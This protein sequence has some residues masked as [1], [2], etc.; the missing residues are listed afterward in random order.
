M[1]EATSAT[2]TSETDAVSP[3]DG[4]AASVVSEDTAKRDA[5]VKTFLMSDGSYEAV[6]Y[7]QPVHYQQDGQWVDI[8]NTLTSETLNGDLLTGDVTKNGNAAN[9][10][11]YWKTTANDFTVEL[12]ASLDTASPVMVSHNGKD[13]RFVLENAAPADAGVTQPQSDADKKAKLTKAEKDADK[14]QKK[15]LENESKTTPKNQDSGADYQNVAA[16]VSLNYA[17]SGQKL[18]ESILLDSPPA[19]TSFTFDVYC[20]NLVAEV[21]PDQ[22]VYLYEKNHK[23]DADPVFVIAAP[24]M[25]DSGE[26]YTDAVAVA[27]TATKYGCTY[28]LTPDADWLNS[29]DRVYPVTLDP[30]VYTSTAPSNILDTYAD[31]SNPNSQYGSTYDMY[32]GSKYIQSGSSWTYYE[33]RTFVKIKDLKTLCI[34][35]GYTLTEADL[36]LHHY[37]GQQNLNIA[38]SWFNLWRLKSSWDPAS[39]TWN[40]L[41]TADIPMGGTGSSN[42]GAIADY[43]TF[44]I[45]NDTF[46]GWYAGTI[47]NCGMELIGSTYTPPSGSASPFLNRLCFVTADFTTVVNGVDPAEYRPMIVVSYAP[48]QTPGIVNGG[49]YY[50]HNSNSGL[51]MDLPNVVFSSGVVLQQNGFT[52]NTSQQWQVNYNSDDGSYA[53]KPINGTAYAMDVYGGTNANDNSIVLWSY[54]STDQ[55]ERFEIVQNP[56][57]SGS[58]RI[59][60]KSSNF[61]RSVVVQS[62]SMS[63]G[64]SIIQ[65]FDN[66]SSNGFWYFEKVPPTPL[67][68]QDDENHCWAACVIMATG[69]TKS[70]SDLN[71]LEGIASNSGADPEHLQDAATRVRASGTPAFNLQ[72]GAITESQV[73]ASINAGYAVIVQIQWGKGGNHDIVICGYWKVNGVYQYLVHD[74]YPVGSG[75]KIM[76]TYSQILTY[77]CP[78]NGNGGTWF[79]TVWQ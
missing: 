40:N 51:Y 6:M 79:A 28:T 48:I 74:P 42:S 69:T 47:A 35:Q 19:Q 30:S 17:V 24:C 63:A 5:S 46:N 58:Y 31:R 4:T 36:R 10:K 41:P 20:K 14:A 16:G 78:A 39:V 55:A 49:T 33:L 68:S 21:Q 1:S 67:I 77:Y 15:Q 70:Q 76:Y 53:L 64:A 8:D 34:P 73:Q 59:L 56:D 44:Q 71:T 2:D 75:Y 23:P 7:S 38:N 25:Y 60:T 26:G 3:N 37:P 52:G 43:N 50:I 62:A 54:S 61:T 65:Y 18:K 12:P 66:R 32:V 27:I 11:A 45:D 29:P 22:S 9:G 57:G 72:Y 13:I